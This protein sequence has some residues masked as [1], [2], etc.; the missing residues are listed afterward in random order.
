VTWSSADPTKVSVNNSGLAS[1]LR[2]GTV[3]ITASSGGKSGT[4]NV[5]VQ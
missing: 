2:K 4:T 5:K 3:T 1:G